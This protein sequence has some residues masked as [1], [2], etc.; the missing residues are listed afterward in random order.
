[1][2]TLRK[3]SIYLIISLAIFACVEKDCSLFFDKPLYTVENNTTD[4]KTDNSVTADIDFCQI[5]AAIISGIYAFNL[6]NLSVEK[7][8]ISDVFY[9][10]NLYFFIWQPPKIS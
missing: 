6:K 2:K 8:I 4:D 10:H 5:D 7:V 9:P 1:M 3:I